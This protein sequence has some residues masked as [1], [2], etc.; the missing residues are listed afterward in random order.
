M[1]IIDTQ[2]FETE[3]K[4]EGVRMVQDVAGKHETWGLMKASLGSSP[5]E[6]T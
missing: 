4:L 6:T 2:P 5:R 3:H 1:P